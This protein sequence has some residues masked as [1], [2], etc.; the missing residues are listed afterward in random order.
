VKTEEK[1]KIAVIG[2]KGFP[3]WGGAARSNESILLRLKDK[4]DITIYAMNTHANQTYYKGIKQIIFKVY[5]GQKI[6]TFIYYIKS[7]FHSLIK[8]NY[9]IIHVNHRAAGLII[10]FLKLRFNVLLNIHGLGNL[11]DKHK[12]YESIIL[13]ISQKIGIRLSDK[14]ITVQQ[15]SVE[16]LNKDNPGNVLFVPNGVDNN[17]KRITKT[18][19]KKYDLTFAAARIIY[20]KGLHTLFA[21]LN[22]VKFD[23]KVQIIGEIKDNSYKKYIEDLSINIKPDYKGIIKD[24]LL[25]FENIVQSKIFIFPSLSEGMSN[26]LLEVVSLKIPVIASNIKQNTEVFN[27]DEILFFKCDDHEDLALKIIWALKNYDT[28]LLM[29]ERAF[30]KIHK[31]HN[32][33][34]IS[35][36]Y[37]KIY[38]GIK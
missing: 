11:Y 12:W 26:M 14:I 1:I 25:L 2:A 33:D 32:W 3:A 36:L 31:N 6:R 37:D 16:I 38:Q 35:L 19:E 10:P 22:K 15:G 34:N 13:N 7:T 17:F 20:L 29:A 21:A 27:S 18:D 8:G 24:R 9:D 28:M 23:G 4:Y 30:E 5:G